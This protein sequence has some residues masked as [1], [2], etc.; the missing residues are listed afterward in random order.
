MG[1]LLVLPSSS[2]QDDALA[3]NERTLDARA[4]RVG[5]PHVLGVYGL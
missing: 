3:A 4:A 1:T 2:R 5:G